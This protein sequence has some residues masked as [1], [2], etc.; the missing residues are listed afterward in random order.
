MVKK[1]NKKDLYL[2]HLSIHGLVRGQDMELGRDSDT[3]GQVKYVVEL[4][5]AL[6]KRPEIKRVDLITRSIIDP[7]VDESYGKTIEKISD[8]A[9]IIRVPFGP[10]RYLRKEVLWPYLD[11]FTDRVLQYFRRVRMVPDL[12]HGHYADAGLAGARL[13]QHLG[14]PLV[15]TGHSLGMIKKQKL[16]DK[17]RSAESIES[18][19]NISARIEAEEMALGNASLIVTSTNQE[20]EDQYKEYDNYHPKRMR[21]IPPGVDLDRFFPYKRGQKRPAIAH[22]L[23]RFLEKPNK[24]VV[25]ALSRPD[26]RKN[27]NTLIHAFAQSQKLRDEA[28]LVIIAGNRNDI[29]KM[30][31]GSKK[32]LVNILLDIDKYDLYGIAAYPKTHMADDVP[33]LYRLAARTKGVF[34]NP[35]LTE[36]FGLTLIEAAASGLPLV[37]TDDGGPRDIVANCHNGILIDP[38]DAEAMGKAIEQFIEDKQ[39]WRAASTS[40][41]KGVKSHYS[42]DTHAVR[43][44]REISSMISPV[45]EPKPRL[46]IIKSKLPVSEKVFITDIDNTLL[47]D[48]K[49]LKKLL[50]YMH[51]HREKLVFGVATGRTLESTI[52]IL[53]QEK[54]PLPEILICAVGSEIYYG[55]NILRD[56][57]WS[58]HIN[59]RWRPEKIREVMKEISGVELQADENQR[60]FKLS[61]NFD[62]SEFSGIRQIR[63][64]MRRND[65]HAKIIHSHGK[66]LDFLPLRASKG[67]AIR[68][69][70]MKWGVDFKN[71]L[72]SGDSGNDREMLSGSTLSV[73]VGNYSSELKNLPETPTI[74][75]AT[76]KY[77]A[78]IIEGMNYYGFLEENNVD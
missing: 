66:F 58:K 6:G 76:D 48:R 5:R 47:G 11:E 30:D 37:A 67:L 73:V 8:K 34:V 9:N 18:R 71:V 38:V 14:V 2:V 27:I 45:V 29:R 22:D 17:G 78:G 12:I 75:F 53:E 16:L 43:Y 23:D 46:P 21:V 59:Y 50:K 60:Q 20:R 64:L 15:F 69:I 44:I 39:K 3:G 31:S 40:G 19:Y 52:N 74:Y 36:P 25:L 56:H 32:V 4:A 62:P 65:L 1:K 28:N 24:P 41:I 33:E 72:V 63:K 26:E 10:K 13:A 77:A 55:P 57:G 7:K 70:C 68:Y 35:A 54:V 51:K 42:W 61:Y 49:A